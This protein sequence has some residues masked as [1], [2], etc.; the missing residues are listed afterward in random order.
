VG[1]DPYRTVEA[2]AAGA[3]PGEH[4]LG[5]RVREQAATDVETQDAALQDRRQSPRT[6]GVQPDGGAELQRGALP[7]VLP[8]EQ[9]IGDS[10]MEVRDWSDPTGWDACL[11]GV[12]AAYI[13]YAPDLAM[14]GATDAIQAFVERAREHGVRRLVLLSG[15]GEP[16]A[17]A[18]ERIV[19]HSGLEWTVVRA[20]WFLQNFSEGAF[21]EMVHAGRI[22][23]PAGDTPE[24][25]V[26]VRDIAEIAVVALLEP[27]HAGEVYEVTGPR[28]LTFADVAADLSAATGRTIAYE[29]VP[30]DGFLEAVRDSGA[31]RDVVWMLDYLFSTVLDGRNAHLTDGVRR[32]LGREPTDL[33]DY[34]HDVVAATLL[35]SLVAGF[36]FAFAVVVMPGLRELDDGAYIRAFQAID[37][38]IQRDDPLFGLVFVGAIVAM[39]AALVLGVPALA[40]VERAMLIGAGALYL[41]GVL[42]PTAAVNVPLNNRLQ[43]VDVVGVEERAA[44]RRAFEERWN[45]WNAVRTGAAVGAAALMT[46]LF[47]I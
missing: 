20:S 33:T 31:P 17:Q 30:H 23:L 46:V 3:A 39:L 44:G 32:A 45:R 21:T 15:R 2:E 16:E 4:V 34:A 12:D 22:T 10:E 18:C 7:T 43:G 29:P 6:L 40:G 5:V 1:G 35:V 26:D 37:G 38:V 19:Q 47:V 25:F 42:V 13:T 24:P 11:G 36:L 14:P 28:L 41:G 27:G 8:C 9:P